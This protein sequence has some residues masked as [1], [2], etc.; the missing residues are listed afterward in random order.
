MATFHVLLGRNFAT[1]GS[2]MQAF[3]AAF[4]I[5]LEPVLLRAKARTP[6][7]L[8]K[9]PVVTSGEKRFCSGQDFNFHT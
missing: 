9:H 6:A 1:I 4:L 2:E 5:I 7:G 3:S 8:Q